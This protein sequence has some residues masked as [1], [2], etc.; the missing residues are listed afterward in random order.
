M[1]GEA[2]GGLLT[3]GATWLT[4][5]P[6]PVLVYLLAAGLLLLPSSWW[7]ERAARL[8]RR[9]AAGWLLVGAALQ[10]APGEGAGQ[11]TGAAAP[12]VRG[13]Q[14]SQPRLLS[15]PPISRIASIAG[16]H[17]ASL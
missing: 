8:A 13:A 7:P 17:P 14:T 15:G 3:S 12:F 2:F 11:Q 16:H 6:G 1:L 5:A 4:G 10:A 9:L